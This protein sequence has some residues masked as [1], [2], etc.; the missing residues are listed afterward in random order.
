MWQVR[1][2][3][4]RKACAVLGR[5]CIRIVGSNPMEV[6]M[7]AFLCVVRSCAGREALQQADPPSRGP[8]K[9]LKGLVLSEVD[10]ELERAKWKVLKAQCV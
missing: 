3:A 6:L 8:T 1:A 9:F 10:S 7:F 4:R 2:A 5:S